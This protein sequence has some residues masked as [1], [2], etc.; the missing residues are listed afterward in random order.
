MTIATAFGSPCRFRSKSMEKEREM[1]EAIMVNAT[2][3][4]ILLGTIT[5]FQAIILYVA[6]KLLTVKRALA[7]KEK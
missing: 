7:S 1:N 4:Y 5:L 6:Y 3:V 2:T